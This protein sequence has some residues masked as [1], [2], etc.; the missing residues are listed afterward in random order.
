MIVPVQLLYNIAVGCHNAP[1]ALFNDTTV[2]TRPVING[3]GTGLEVASKEIIFGVYDSVTGLVKHPY[4]GFKHGAGRAGGPAWGAVKGA[5]RGIGGIGFRAGAIAFAIPGYGL[6]GVEQ[7][8]LRIGRNS[9]A[10][11]AMDDE[12]LERMDQL[13]ELDQRSEEQR[14]KDLRM[15]AAGNDVL[16]RRVQQAADRMWREEYVNKETE[17]Q[18][19]EGWE[20][21]MRQRPLS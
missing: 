2:R 4:Y 19:L 5:G 18:I 8:L 11:P 14:K 12:E 17:A 1:F 16:E 3:V 9:E 15:V 20:G 7:A 13:E 21:L 6:K 10:L